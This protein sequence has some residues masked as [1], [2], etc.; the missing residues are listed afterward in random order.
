[1]DRLGIV[2]SRLLTVMANHAFS[3]EPVWNWHDAWLPMHRDTT[4]DAV[5]ARLAEPAPA[6][7]ARA[8]VM[9]LHEEIVAL[10]A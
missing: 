3:Y 4:G 1:M 8:L 10:L 9:R 2:V 6:P 5:R 7:E